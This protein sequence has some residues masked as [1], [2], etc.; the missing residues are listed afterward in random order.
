M[1]A[2]GV[3][4]GARGPAR[5]RDAHRHR[6]P[7]PRG[8]DAVVM[9]EHDRAVD[10]DAR[11]RG[12]PRRRAGRSSSLRRLRHR[13][14]RDAA[15]RGHGDRLARDRHAGRL[16]RRRAR[17]WRRRPRVG[18]LS[19]GDE[20]VAAGRAAADRPR[21]TT[22]TARSSPP[23]SPRRR[24][25]GRLGSCRTT[26]P[27]SARRSG[28]ALAEC[29]MRRPV[30]RHVEGRGRRLATAGRGAR[31]ARASSRTASR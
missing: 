14:R 16:R 21:S 19:T 10:G 6:R 11:D 31:R 13:A 26:R 1:I 17:R 5:H 24:R 29:D 15:P 3:G 25:A 4:A 27:R 2:C 28:R 20:L 9:V 7:V 12:R 8:A 22:P 30:R 18:V 23:R